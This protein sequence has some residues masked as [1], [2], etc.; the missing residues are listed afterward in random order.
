MYTLH[1]VLLTSPRNLLDTVVGEATILITFGKLAY[2]IDVNTY[3][4]LLKV[5]HG[6]VIHSYS[7]FILIIYEH[8]LCICI[9]DHEDVT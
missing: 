4:N 6:V 8:H 3:I 5:A 7:Q 2:K 9:P 1:F